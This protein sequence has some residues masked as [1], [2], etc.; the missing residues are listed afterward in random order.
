MS[1]KFIRL[2]SYVSKRP[3]IWIGVF[4][5]V[6]IIITGLSLAATPARIIY[7]STTGSDTN[8]GTQ[9]SPLQSIQKALNISS[10]GDTILVNSGIYH[11][12]INLSPAQNNVT[13]RGTGPTQPVIEGDNSR[14]IGIYM[15]GTSSG[16][17]TGVTIDNFEVRDMNS[18]TSSGRAVGIQ[19]GAYASNDLIEN[20]N[21]HDIHSSSSYSYGIMVGW[22]PGSGIPPGSV[23]DVLINNNK[24]SN[25]GPGGEAMGIW[26]LF[27]QNTTVSNNEIYLVRKEGIRDW[28]GKDDIL[29]NNIL[30]LNWIGITMESTIGGLV[31]NNVAYDNVYGFNLKHANGDTKTTAIWQIYGGDW[32]K[33]WHNTSFKNTHADIGLG[34]NLNSGETAPDND[35]LDI[36]DN[37]FA[38]PGDVHLHDFPGVRGPHVSIDG[39]AYSG[40]AW[41]DMAGWTVPPNYADSYQS[42]SDLQTGKCYLIYKPNPPATCQAPLGWE[43]HGQIFTPTFADASIGN[44]NFNNTGLASGVDLSNQSNLMPGETADSLGSQIGARLTRTSTNSWVAYPASVIASSPEYG[45]WLNMQSAADGRDNTYWWSNSST[46]WQI[47]DLG[48]SQ[49]INTFILDIFAQFDSRNPKDINIEVSND[50]VNYKSVYAVINHDSEGSSYKYVLNSPVTARYIK[51]SLDSFGASTVIFSDFKIGLLTPLSSNQITNNQP[52]QVAI[53]SPKSSSSLTAPTNVTLQATANSSDSSIA[54]VDFYNGN[55][56]IGESDASPF[57]F[58]WIG[59]GQGQYSIT[60][61]ATDNNG[62]VATSNPVNITVATATTSGGTGCSILVN[63]ICPGQTIGRDNLSALLLKFGSNDKFADL[64]GDGTVNRLDMSLLLLKFGSTPQ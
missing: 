44:F 47:Y 49:S 6:G 34:M 11:E 31:E 24:V 35:Y 60:A 42:L 63:I 2:H 14:S 28:G 1:D 26:M 43:V 20:N 23:H 7:V 4:S 38:S 58:N 62:N 41:V 55:T 57:M 36:R 48:A 33:F 16:D 40:S 32:V 29:T 9:T 56:L 54:K 37:V 51:L 30:Y 15:S 10:A 52:P 61:K 13:L 59:V 21:V 64:N 22:N 46:G 18:N 3:F 50:N 53:T 19:I 27:T 25:I 45:R 12:S 17:I 39:N 5:I 8:N